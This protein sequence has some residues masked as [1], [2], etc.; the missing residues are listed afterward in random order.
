MDSW[1]LKKKKRQK[2]KEIE[3]R[4]KMIEK[5]KGRGRVKIEGRDKFWMH[6]QAG[7]STQG[8]ELFLYH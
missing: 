4:K 8:W 2:L 7:F 3:R 5:E 6:S 1:K